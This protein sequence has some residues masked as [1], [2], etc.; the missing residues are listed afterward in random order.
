MTNSDG[1]NVNVNIPVY[2]ASIIRDSDSL[3]DRIDSLIRKCPVASSTGGYRFLMQGQ[4][5]PSSTLSYV[6]CEYRGIDEVDAESVQIFW[7]ST[8]LNPT[9]DVWNS[10]REWPILNTDEVKV[11]GE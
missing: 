8:D 3:W 4:S 5:E 9:I 2:E 7:T 1:L 6:T 11:H 10:D